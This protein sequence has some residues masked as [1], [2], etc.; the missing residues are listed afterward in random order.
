MDKPQGYLV[1]KSITNTQCSILF[2]LRSKCLRGIRDNF[3]QLYSQNSMCPVCERSIYSSWPP[4]PVRCSALHAVR[5]RGSQTAK[6]AAP[7]L[8]QFCSNSFQLPYISDGYI[9]ISCPHPLQTSATIY[10]L[11]WTS[12]SST[13]ATLPYIYISSASLSATTL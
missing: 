6:T 9:N 4:L 7:Y 8:L 5:G 2:A 11:Q 10:T 1:D 13:T 3:K 12:S